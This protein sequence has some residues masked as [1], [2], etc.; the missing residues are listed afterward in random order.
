MLSDVKPL[1]RKVAVHIIDKI[2]SIV[3]ER[4]VNINTSAFT[5]HCSDKTE[6]TNQDSIRSYRKEGTCGLDGLTYAIADGV[7]ASPDAKEW[8]DYLADIGARSGA[9]KDT[10]I[11]NLFESVEQ[12][13]KSWAER[14]KKTIE[15]NQSNWRFNFG[16]RSP[17]HAPNGATICTVSFRHDEHGIFFDA[18]AR[19]DSCLFHFKN[20]LASSTFFPLKSVD[21]F[22][23][24]PAAIF[25]ST[26]RV[27]LEDS[28]GGVCTLSN[29]KVEVGDVIIIATDAM[30]KL[31]MQEMFAPGTHSR[32]IIEDARLGLE[33]SIKAKL[34][35]LRK[36]AIIEDDDTSFVAIEIT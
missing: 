28:D 3:N 2:T 30:A 27:N 15:E 12:Y 35:A 29:Q 24:P 7:S 9:D 20:D 10:F 31:I 17:I 4:P 33:D 13:Q 34:T 1:V 21:D 25:D 6:Q 19:G 11:K 22:M 14:K 8:A 23:L 26:E 5:F 36:S 18:L 16:E 32:Q